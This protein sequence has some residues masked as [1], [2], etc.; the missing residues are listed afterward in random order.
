MGGA[1][2][3]AVTRVTPSGFEKRRRL[4]SSSHSPDCSGTK[5]KEPRFKDR[6]S[7]SSLVRAPRT[8]T[9]RR[10]PLVPFLRCN[11]RGHVTEGA[12]AAA[13]AAA[14]AA[15]LFVKLCVRARG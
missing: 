13:A 4:L 15:M 9:P 3:G 11:R 1:S 5:V 2:G 12:A 8:T 7:S 14:V 6:V 10:A